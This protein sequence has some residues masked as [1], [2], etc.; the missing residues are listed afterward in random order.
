MQRRHDRSGPFHIALAFSVGQAH[1]Q[2]LT[3]GIAAYAGHEGRWIL[4][5]AGEDGTLSIE[6]LEGWRG[7]GIIAALTRPSEVRIAE[8]FV[9]AGIPVVTISGALR[10][11]GVPRVMVANEDIGKLA[12]EHLFQCGFRHFGFYGLRRVAYS[13]DRERGFAAQ[14]KAMGFSYAPRWAPSTY[15]RRRPW[16]DDLEGL[17][18]WLRRLTPPLGIFAV[19]D[20]RAR[21]I[22]DACELAKLDVPSQIAVVGADNDRVVCEFSR[23]G[24]SSI[25][26]DWHRVGYEAARTVHRILTGETPDVETRIPP[27]EVVRRSSTAITV[28]GDPQLDHVITYIHDHP[29]E[30]FGVERLLEIGDVSRRKL[31]QAFRTSLRMTPYEYLCRARIDRAKMLLQFGSSTKLTQISR[32]CGFRDARR[33]RLVFR[34]LEGLTPAAY[35]KNV[36]RND[37]SA[38]SVIR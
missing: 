2:S 22:L 5:T 27:R 13:R 29:E 1:L 14:L 16:Q 24:L 12:A 15:D 30:V 34:R 37:F 38:Q 23:P 19:N 18:Q 8:R 10:H 17:R 21:L 33:F 20:F 7:D 25:D 28:T 32:L 9:R 26:C 11:P 31:E 6:Q 35:R 36:R 4:T 3:Q